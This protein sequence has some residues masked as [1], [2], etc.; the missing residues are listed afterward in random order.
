MDFGYISRTLIAGSQGTH[1]F[2][3]S[4]HSPKVFEMIVANSTLSCNIRYFPRVQILHD[5]RQ[6]RLNSFWP[7]GWVC[8]GVS[9]ARD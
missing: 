1:M 2:N 9:P 8:C 5:I 4:K 3:V 6:C 7:F